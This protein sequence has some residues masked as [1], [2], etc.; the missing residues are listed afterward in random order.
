MATRFAASAGAERDD[1][2]VVV[3]PGRDRWTVGRIATDLAMVMVA[4][5]SGLDWLAPRPR[6]GCGMTT[7]LAVFAMGLAILAIR[8][9]W[10]A[11]KIANDA[12]ER[13]IE[14]FNRD[15]PSRRKSKSEPLDE[16]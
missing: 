10:I 13:I 14:A 1:T 8:A 16:L 12:G 2:M 5:P 15:E 6:G 11:L 3:G 9:S 7:D 4:V